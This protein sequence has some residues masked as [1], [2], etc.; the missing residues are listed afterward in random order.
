MEALKR[1]GQ[2]SDLTSTPVV[3]KMRTDEKVG[4]ENGDSRE[5]VRRY[6]KLTELTPQLLKMVD[7]GKIAFRPAVELAHL[8]KAHQKFLLS[9][10]EAEQSTPSLSQ[11][12][13]LKRYSIDGFLDDSK[14]TALMQE[15]KPNQKESIRIPYEK[16]APFLKKDMVP[17][18]IVDLI[19]KAMTEHHQRTLQRQRNH[20][21]R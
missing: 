3:S 10:M 11:A 2:L 4:L 17:V 19:V 9:I 16:L 18:D 20:D 1:Q 8:S 5:Q 15:Q 6:V 21:A 12:Q 13:K 14:I 7:E